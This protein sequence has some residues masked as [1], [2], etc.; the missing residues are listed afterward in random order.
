[1]NRFAV[2]TSL[3]LLP[4]ILS[5]CVD[6][7]P[8]AYEAPARVSLDA[9]PAGVDA[10]L[11]DAC[12]T[13][14]NT[15]ACSAQV[16][17][18]L[19]NPLSAAVARCLV[20]SYCLNWQQDISHLPPCVFACANKTGISSQSDPAIVPVVPVIICGQDHTA[21]GCGAVCDPESQD[22]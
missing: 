4:A 15:G 18:A 20:D 10:A 21:A 17:G 19:S 9:G 6:T 7:S 12:K 5:A 13:C 14:M 11:V 8:I 3:A 1:V 16:A 22:D 2:V